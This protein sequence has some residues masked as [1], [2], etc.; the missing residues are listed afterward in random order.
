MRRL[1]VVLVAA[2]IVGLTWW[3]VSSRHV[4][5]PRPMPSELPA[6]VAPAAALQGRV[7][8]SSAGSSS[9]LTPQETVAR[10]R[11]RHEASRTQAA[12]IVTAGH[13]KLLSL[14]QSEHIDARWAHDREQSLVSHSVSQQIKDL[15]AE[16]KNMSVHCR[17]TT[18]LIGAD[19]AT[20]TAAD[21]W[22]T[23][24][25]TNPGTNLS[26]ISSQVTANPDGS[27]HIQIYGLAKQ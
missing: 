12:E 2:L 1:A 25:A 22:L 13:N 26:N 17:S 19:F 6:T 20:P 11:A 7:A 10:S 15:K 27:A 23:L 5:E 18:C 4:L 16:P 24:F 9:Y 21:D 3:K 8:S 14:Y